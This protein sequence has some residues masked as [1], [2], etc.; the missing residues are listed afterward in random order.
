MR[1]GRSLGAQGLYGGILDA[2]AHEIGN[3]RLA[4][5]CPCIFGVWGQSRRYRNQ[6]GKRRRRVFLRKWQLERRIGSELRIGIHPPGVGLE[7]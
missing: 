3:Y 7:L 2:I 1:G 6:R 4:R 5:D